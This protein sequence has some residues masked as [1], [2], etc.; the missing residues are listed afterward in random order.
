[1]LAGYRSLRAMRRVNGFADV[2]RIGSRFAADPSFNGPKRSR[3]NG[4][5]KQQRG[6]AP[7]ATAEAS[8][9]DE[10]HDVTFRT[11]TINAY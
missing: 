9:N 1:M 3:S 6:S 10:F 4:S 2:D 5:T 11:L 8:Q 7:A